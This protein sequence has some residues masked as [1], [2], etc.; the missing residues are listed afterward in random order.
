MS[1]LI[2]YGLKGRSRAE[3]V[4]WVLQELQLPHQFIRL[5]FLKFENKS[6]DY[7]R[8]NPQEK[9]P[10]LVDG[11]FVLSESMAICF[12]LCNLSDDFTLIPKEKKQ[13]A[14]FYQRIFFALTALEPYLWLSDKERFIKDEEMPVGVGDYSIRK[15]SEAFVSINR[16]LETTPYIAGETFTLADILYYHLVTW[17]CL[18]GIPQT[19][20]VALY[21][22]RLS[23]REAFPQSMATAGSPAVTG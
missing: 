9:V 23:G 20:A 22:K 8:L 18:Y 7:L 16:W 11:D 1:E 4:L 3:R 14:V 21:I 5:D 15:I 12:Y 17:A 6:Q 10:T 19:E 2:L 13:A